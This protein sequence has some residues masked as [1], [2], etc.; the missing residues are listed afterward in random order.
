MSKADDY[1]ITGRWIVR[2]CKMTASGDG[3]SE[4]QEKSAEFDAVLLCLGFY[5]IPFTP[6]G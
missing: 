3:E 5:R 4:Q 2:T 1:E 6:S